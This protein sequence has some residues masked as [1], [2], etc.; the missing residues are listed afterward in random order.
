MAWTCKKCGIK[1]T[2]KNSANQSRCK[3]CHNQYMRD[4][5]RTEYMREYMR[6]QRWLEGGPDNRLLGEKKKSIICNVKNGK[7]LLRS[8]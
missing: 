1:L 8:K 4:Y 5:D 3:S 7:M 2:L 6:E